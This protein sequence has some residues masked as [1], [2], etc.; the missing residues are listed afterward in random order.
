M[1]QVAGGNYELT[2]L[3]S[4][5]GW[6][7]MQSQGRLLAQVLG[8]RGLTDKATTVTQ[9]AVMEQIK[10]VGSSCWRQAGVGWLHGGLLKL[11]DVGWLY[12][13]AQVC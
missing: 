1:A 4:S 5:N 8:S 10:V 11:V 7:Q 3:G 13:L 2:D 9:L 6:L 12:W